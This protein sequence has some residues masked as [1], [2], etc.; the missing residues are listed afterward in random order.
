MV[1]N[2]GGYSTTSLVNTRRISRP[3]SFYVRLRVP[4]K[5]LQDTNSPVQLTTDRLKFGIAYDVN[6]RDCGYVS[7][8]P[9]NGYMAFSFE[10][11]TRAEASAVERIIR[12][13]F[14]DVAVLN[15]FE[16]LDVAGVA[17]FLGHK[18]EAGTYEDYVTV[19]RKLFVHMVE[20]AKLVFPGKYLGQYGIEYQTTTNVSSRKLTGSSKSIS[21]TMAMEYGFRTPSIA[22]TNVSEEHNEPLSSKLPPQLVEAPN[23]HAWKD[24]PFEDVPVFVKMEGGEDMYQQVACNMKRASE[25][26]KAGKA[27]HDYAIKMWRIPPANIDESFY[28]NHV[29]ADDASSSF[30][31]AWR[32]VAA[33]ESNTNAVVECSQPHGRFVGNRTVHAMK[34]VIG[35][36]FLASITD[37]ESLATLRSLQKISV[38]EGACMAAYKE[39]VDGLSPEEKPTFSRVFDFKGTTGCMAAK[40]ILGD[41]FGM[42]AMRRDP[43]SDRRHYHTI[44]LSH[45]TLKFMIEKYGTDL[46][47]PT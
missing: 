20:I 17:T 16:Y 44:V 22:W 27:L 11:K 1:C 26:E 25:A 38:E 30:F 18:Y 13:Q 12:A 14:E 31:K 9:D 21:D 19:G 23:K 2:L 33:T 5:L 3:A 4:H 37:A 43:K 15:S 29:K 10:C 8:D 35:R 40:K 34:L 32:F 47:R 36:K 42:D 45:P 28:E 24:I 41:C 7:T 39:I 6:N 46:Y